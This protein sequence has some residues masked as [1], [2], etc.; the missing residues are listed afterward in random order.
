MICSGFIL[1]FVILRV[2]APGKTNT[3]SGH[4]FQNYGSHSNNY[5]TAYLTAA[6]AVGMTQ[7]DVDLFVARL[8]K[9]LSKFKGVKS[10]E[11]ELSKDS[12]IG[13]SNISQS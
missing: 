12:S 7:S 11:L 8:D 1:K 5:P 6:A 13:D 3:V 9:V 10:N 2:V 4:T